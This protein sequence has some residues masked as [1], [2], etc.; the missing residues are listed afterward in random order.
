MVGGM[1]ELLT[2]KGQRS[3]QPPLSPH[4]GQALATQA[5]EFIRLAG[6]VRG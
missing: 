4:M 3:G 1:L 2:S 6:A 5:V